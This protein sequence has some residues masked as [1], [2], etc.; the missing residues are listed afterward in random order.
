MDPSKSWETYKKYFEQQTHETYKTYI[1]VLAF[2]EYICKD[3]EPFYPIPAG[4]MRLVGGNRRQSKKNKHNKNNKIVKRLTKKL[5]KKL[6]NRLT[7]RVIKR[8]SKKK[9]RN[10]P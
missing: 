1:Q 9:K 5:T 10:T 6:T 7:K 2:A 4:G 8:L 3:R